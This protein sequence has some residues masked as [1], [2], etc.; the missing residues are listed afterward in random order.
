MVRFFSPPKETIRNS[1]IREKGSLCYLPLILHHCKILNSKGL[2][3][4][5]FKSSEDFEYFSKLYAEC[6][7]SHF[8]NNPFIIS[9][10]YCHRDI[11]ED[12]LQNWPGFSAVTL[13]AFSVQSVW[14]IIKRARDRN[15]SS[16][17]IYLYF[18]QGLICLMSKNS[19]GLKTLSKQNKVLYL[20]MATRRRHTGQYKGQ[21]TWY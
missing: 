18:R 7:C 13:V 5:I 14:C 19:P 8:Q 2:L 1:Q 17:I 11:M 9:H 10:W 12:L 3:K 15:F 4:N 16:L 20:K 21:H 6:M